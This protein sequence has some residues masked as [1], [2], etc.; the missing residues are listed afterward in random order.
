MKILRGVWGKEHM[1]QSSQRWFRTLFWF[2]ACSAAAKAG[3]DLQ[4]SYRSTIDG[5]DQPYRMYVP[6]SYRPDQPIPLVIALHQTGADENSFFEDESHYPS[7]EGLKNAAETYGVLAVCPNARG[8]TVYRGMGENAVLCVLEDVQKRFIVDPDRIYLT[9]H[10]MG[11]TGSADLALHH[12]DL[13]A[14]VAPLAAARSIRWLAANAGHVPFWW[15]GGGADQEYYKMG[16]AVGV[17]RMKRLGCPVTFTELDGEGHYGTARNFHRVV[18]WLLQHRRIA[19]PRAFVFEVDTL[20]HSRAYW[21]TVDA[22]ARPGTVATVKARADSQ[23]AASLELDNVDAVSFWP[24]PAVFDLKQPLELRLNSVRIFSDLLSPAQEVAVVRDSAGWKSDVR[25]RRE[26][27]LTAYRI[28]PIAFAPATLD[29][30]G[31]EARLGNWI[32]D[33]MRA[34]TGADVA[35]YNHRPDRASLPIRAGTVDIVDLLQCSLPGDQDLVMV[36]LSGRDLIEILAANIPDVAAEP[37]PGIVANP[38]VQISGANYAFD[39]RLPPARRVVTTSLDPNKT[40]RVV[41]EGQVVERETI[42]LAGRFKKLKY[43]TTDIPFTLALYGHAVRAR[44]LRSSLE[45]RVKELN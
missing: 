32:T 40:Y 22:I 6:S 23:H 4:L 38:L 3:Q 44:Q 17:E 43:E 11:G 30:N 36:K 8:N 31:T 18:E 26:I 33:A 34:A 41:M 39:R 14:A 37:A 24:D 5:T 35:L 15:I 19:H 12:P 9:G 27:S 1:G 25:P 7:K 21:I 29:L 13:F 10:S 2:L 28:H 20:L 42:R 45:G 16:V